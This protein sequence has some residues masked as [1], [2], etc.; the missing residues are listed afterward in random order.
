MTTSDGLGPTVFLLPGLDGSGPGHWQTRW[1]ALLPQARWVA[2]RDWSAPRREEWVAKLDA[3]VRASAGPIV[4]AAHSLGCA[5]A[6]SWAA[7]FGRAPHAHKVVGALLVAPPDVE[8]ADAPAAVRDFAPMPLIVL[9]FRS[10]VVASTDDPWCAL[11]RARTW[12]ACWGAQWQELGAYGHINAA[13]GLAD[14]DQGQ[15]WLRQLSQSI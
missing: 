12:A 9:P 11:A 2:Q 8:R 14:W 4:F 3:A 15:R 6:V 5:T 7:V 13:S 10:L 1:Q